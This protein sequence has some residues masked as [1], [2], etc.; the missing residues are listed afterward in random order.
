MPN[1]SDAIDEFT[2]ARTRV[3]D[4]YGVLAEAEDFQLSIH[5]DALATVT[6]CL[7]D[8]HEELTEA[9]RILREARDA[10]SGD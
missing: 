2:K 6:I 9:L 3:D 7:D 8:V 4:L 1:L 10:A 5:S